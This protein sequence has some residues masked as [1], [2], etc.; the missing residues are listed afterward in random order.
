[1]LKKSKGFQGNHF[2]SYLKG[3]LAW[4]LIQKNSEYGK[5]YRSFVLSL[6]SWHCSLGTVE[7]ISVVFLM[8]QPSSPLQLSVQQY[9]E[10]S[11][12]NCFLKEN[13]LWKIC[14]PRWVTP[15]IDCRYS[16]A[17]LHVLMQSSI[18]WCLRHTA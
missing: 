1:M 6:L 10:G 8:S 18:S 15:G 13:C 7:W 2:W 3:N 9:S 4:K 12:R 16:V 17:K 5:V 14:Q 11:Q